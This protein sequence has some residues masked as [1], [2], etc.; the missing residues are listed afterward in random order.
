M[1]QGNPTL[2]HFIDPLQA[3]PCSMDGYHW[4]LHRW[5]ERLA[6][7]SEA[8]VKAEKVSGSPEELVSP[9][10]SCSA[11]RWCL[12]AARIRQAKP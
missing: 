10:T 7:D 6:S 4:C 5:N 12:L 11:L 3:I 9:C 1:H 8:T 2:L